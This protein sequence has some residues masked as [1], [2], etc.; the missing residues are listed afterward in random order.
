YYL[1]RNWPDGVQMEIPLRKRDDD[2]LLFK[3]VRDHQPQITRYLGGIGLCNI[4]PEPQFK[5]QGALAEFGE[6]DLRLWI[7]INES[8]A[9]CHI[10][11]NLC[12]PSRIRPVSHTDSHCEPH[13]AVGI[14]PVGEVVF[15]QGTVR[16]ESFGSVP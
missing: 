7:F 12:H 14:R 15:Q 11:K 2:P 3:R 6:E 10:P 16:D 5:I 9:L 8:V 13:L 4:H 1:Y